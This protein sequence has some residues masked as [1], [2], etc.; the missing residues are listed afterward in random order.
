MIV[1]GSGEQAAMRRAARLPLVNHGQLRL[2]RRDLDRIGYYRR[3]GIHTRALVKGF[4][5]H[6]GVCLATP[7]H[8][9]TSRCVFQP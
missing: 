1:R 8:L 2:L 6:S 3:R 5:H 9:Q 7:A 4:L